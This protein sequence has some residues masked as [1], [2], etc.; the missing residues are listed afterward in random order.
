[1]CS[2][3]HV[4]DDKKGHGFV[5]PTQINQLQLNPVINEKSEMFKSMSNK[6]WSTTIKKAQ[7]QLTK[8]KRDLVSTNIGQLM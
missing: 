3:M 8:E 5:N 2:L 6:E 7:Q 4:C 1:M